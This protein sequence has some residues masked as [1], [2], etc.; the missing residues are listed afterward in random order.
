MQTYLSTFSYQPYDQIVE[1]NTPS[2]KLNVDWVASGAVRPVRNQGQCIADY[3]FSAIGGIE[4]IA[5]I[6]YKLN[7]E[8]SPQEI[9]DCWNGDGCKGGS[10]EGAYSFIKSRGTA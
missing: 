7:L 2:V 4:G 10:M 9:I 8:F 1:S 3:A 5:A 6:F